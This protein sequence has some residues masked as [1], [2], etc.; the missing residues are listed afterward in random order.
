MWSCW[1]V[2]KTFAVVEVFRSHTRKTSI[3]CDYTCITRR[4]AWIALLV[5]SISKETIKA[6]RNTNLVL[7]I[8]EV[9]GRTSS[10]VSTTTRTLSAI[11]ITG[12][13]GSI[14]QIRPSRTSTNT[15]AIWRIKNRIGRYRLRIASRA[16]IIWS[17]RSTLSTWTIISPWIWSWL[18]NLMILRCVSL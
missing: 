14:K 9:T 7:V 10:T 3:R 17:T 2:R 13:T 4:C 15:R 6:G 8:K 12:R 16:W 11:T 5:T 18:T 1:A